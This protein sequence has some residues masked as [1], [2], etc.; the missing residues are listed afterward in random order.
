MRINAA[1]CELVNKNFVDNVTCTLKPTR[2]GKGKTSVMFSVVNPTRD[3]WVDVKTFYRN[4]A[5]RLIPFFRSFDYD[6]CQMLDQKANVDFFAKFVFDELK[7]TFP[8][9][10]NRTC[11]FEGRLGFEDANLCEILE[12]ALIDLIPQGTYKLLFRFYSKKGNVTQLQFYTVGEVRAVNV[13]HEI[14]MI[15][16]GRTVYT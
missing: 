4:S 9:F 8:T 6:L 2:N 11:P 12:N 10:L 5:L 15:Q 14:P 13:L 16:A 3:I 1:G 7:R